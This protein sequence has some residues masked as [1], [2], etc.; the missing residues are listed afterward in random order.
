MHP[1]LDSSNPIPNR[2][3]IGDVAE[4]NFISLGAGVQSTVMLLMADQGLIDP[5][6]QAAIFADTRWEPEAIYRHLDW[7]EATVSNVPVIRVSN[8]RDLIRETHSGVIHSGRVDTIIPAF[9][10]QPDDRISMI[11]SRECT[12]DYKI[13]PITREI[14]RLIGRRPGQRGKSPAAI[15]WLGISLDETLRIKESS[16]SWI[17]NRWPLVEMRM[18]RSDCRAWFS[19]HYPGQPL[20]KSSCMGCAFH[21]DEEWLQ[22]FRQYPEQ[23]AQVISLDERLRDDDRPQGNLK[24]KP[25]LHRSAAPLRQAIE[26]IRRRQLI[27]PR[28]PA[29]DDFINECEGYC[30]V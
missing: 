17:I 20:V 13:R 18:R 11:A 30:G 9:Y 21:S 3:E 28:L 19:E 2:D 22:L 29:L 1:S 25:Y 10:R 4:Y 5:M 27:N 24:A 6:P 23:M 15:Q 16:T 8:D 14:G 12:R 26:E 7:L